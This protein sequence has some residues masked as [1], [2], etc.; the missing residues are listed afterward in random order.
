MFLTKALLPQLKAAAAREHALPLGVQRAAV[1][2]MSTAVA[3]LAENTG[4][5][6]TA[7]RAS[8]TALNMVMKNL[9]IE[10]KG[11]GILVLA[12]HPGWVK[13]DMGGP[14]AMIDTDLCCSTMVVTL[15][16]AGEKEH[17]AFLRYNNTAIP[18]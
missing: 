1:V 8:K 13:T 2:M 3:S 5:G 12:M 14:N 4:G 18:W 7:Y 10:L 9:S 16:A 11:D 15:D 17:G 6:L